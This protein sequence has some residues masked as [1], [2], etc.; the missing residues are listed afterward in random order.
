MKWEFAKDLANNID[1]FQSFSYVQN[2]RSVIPIFSREKLAWRF[3]KTYVKAVN[4]VIPFQV[5]HVSGHVFA[6]TLFADAVFIL[7]PECK[8]TYTLSQQ[9]IAAISGHKDRV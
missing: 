5:L 9:D 6:E 8:H 2:N 4:L 3:I 1:G 7:N